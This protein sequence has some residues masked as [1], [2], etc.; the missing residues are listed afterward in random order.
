MEPQRRGAAAAAW[1]PGGPRCASHV[2]RS[3]PGTIS[4]VETS[5]RPGRETRQCLHSCESAFPR[6]PL[7]IGCR[8]PGGVIQAE[9]R[10]H[11]SSRSKACCPPTELSLSHRRHGGSGACGCHDVVCGG[12]AEPRPAEGRT[13]PALR[14]WAAQ[15]P[16]A[17]PGPGCAGR[18]AG[19]AGCQ[20]E[21]GRAEP[22][23]RLSSPGHTSPELRPPGVRGRW[24]ARTCLAPR[25]AP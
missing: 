4:V 12:S 5:C 13:G 22:G 21:R 25:P 8:P 23:G 11:P 14:H 2:D 9:P 16:G 17:G 7:K 15:P 10:A 6:G 3:S 18:G 24:R 19:A 1:A 20:M